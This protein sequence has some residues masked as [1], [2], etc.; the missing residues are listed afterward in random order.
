MFQMTDSQQTTLR[1]GGLADKKGNPV[2]G[3]LQ[4]APQWST[5]NTDVVA[6]TPAADGQSCL[7][8]AVGPLGQANVTLKLQA[9]FGQGP[10]PIVGTF[11][12]TIT[13][14]SATQVTITADPPSEEA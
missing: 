11:A 12:V 3:T 6:L 2:T 10:V 5:D 8:A 4:G 13:G 7:V 1:V 14:G 9:D